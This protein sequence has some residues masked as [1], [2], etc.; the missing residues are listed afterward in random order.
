MQDVGEL[1][2]A[3]DAYRKA[4]RA[5][6]GLR[7]RQPELGHA[8]RQSRRD[9]SSA[10]AFR[11]SPRASSGIRGRAHEDGLDD[12]AR[13]RASTQAG[14]NTNGVCI[15]DSFVANNPLRVV[16]FPR[17]DGSSLEGKTHPHR[18]EQGIGDEIMFASC[19]RRRDRT[20]EARR[21]RVRS[22]S[23]RRST[24]ARSPSTT[25]LA[26]GSSG[27]IS[28][29][30]RG[31]ARD[32]LPHS[33]LGSLPRFCRPTLESFAPG[34][35]Y[36]LPDP[37]LRTKWRAELART[38]ATAERRHLVARRSRPA[39]GSRALH[40]RSPSGMPIL[41]FAGATFVNV[42]YGD[43]SAEVTD[44]EREP[45]VR[46]HTLAGIDPLDERR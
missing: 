20:G 35:A 28:R 9:G 39:I 25:V 40:S 4:L 31:V 14:A 46:V 23:R 42:Q 32:R 12:A 13:G 27:L 45:G 5:G 8:A 24:L 41:R 10:Q 7:D 26:R 2:A 29:W 34:S 38:R 37:E 11:E 15:S 18:P 43:H 3:T 1:D 21:D 30:F 22:A 19:Y 16:P 6:S 33:P 44:V 36:L 17:W